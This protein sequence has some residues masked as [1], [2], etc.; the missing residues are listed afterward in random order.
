MSRSRGPA[1]RADATDTTA[2]LRQAFLTGLALTIPLVLTLF[3]LQIAL[4]FVGSVV[5]PIVAGLE[6]AVGGIGAPDVLVEAATV[7]T[8]GTLIL[9][10]GLAAES[11]AGPDHL[12]DGFDALMAR[13]PGLGSVYTGIRRMSEVLLEQDTESF[14]EVS[15]VEFPREG[16]YMLA[17]VTAEPPDAVHEAAD[18]GDMQTL[19]VPLAPNPVMG[20]FLVNLPVERVHDLDLTVEEGVQAIVTSGTAL[21]PRIEDVDDAEVPTIADAEGFVGDV[22]RG[23]VLDGD[24]FSGEEDE[25]AGKR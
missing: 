23:D 7:L 22:V 4:N 1:P 10:I 21:D 13:V 16:V 3:V 19:F 11:R 18:A 9:L 20:G 5:S 2:L 12:S 24:L 8:L 15:L 6:F 25:K 14:Q 17:F